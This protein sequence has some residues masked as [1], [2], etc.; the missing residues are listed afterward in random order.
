MGYIAC[1]LDHRGNRDSNIALY[2]NWWIAQQLP[3]SP[4]D[5]AF[6]RCS[7]WHGPWSWL[8]GAPHEI[9]LRLQIR[10]DDGDE[11]S[12]VLATSDVSCAGLG[13]GA[14]TNPTVSFDTIQIANG[15]KAWVVIMFE[16]APGP[17]W[18]STGWRV[19]DGNNCPA[20]ITRRSLDGGISWGAPFVNYPP[21]CADFRLYAVITA[22]TVVTDAATNIEEETVTL[23]GEITA[24][25]AQDA[26]ERGFD[27]GLDT[28]YGNSW[29]ESDSYGIAAFSHAISG[30]SPGTTIHFR[31]KAHN[32]AG[33]G[34]GDDLT[35]VTKPEAC[36]NMVATAISDSQ[37]DVTWTKG[38]GAVNTVVRR[39]VGAYPATIADGEEAYNGPSASFSDQGLDPSTAYYYRAWSY[40]DPHYADAYCQDNATTMA[41]PPAILPPTVTTE[42]ANNINQTLAT[43]NGVLTND[44][45]EACD[46][47]FEYAEV[48]G[49]IYTTAVQGG[50][51]TGAL[52][53]AAL[54]GLTPDTRYH[55]RA[56][57]RNS[58]GTSYGANMYF[59]TESPALVEYSL[60]Q[61]E[62]AELLI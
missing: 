45:G 62:L 35:F 4:G 34:Y 50:K 52:F 26:D 14:Y 48:G 60:L 22:P 20:G 49:T 18:P 17:W 38:D 7:I 12:A 6:N 8:P 16:P 15:Q 37:I 61:P 21:K 28:S 46:C 36:T 3:P 10:S 57:A 25:G 13:E 53:S 9:A 58:T 39:A 44:G 11:P 2:K 32:S 56:I 47:W 40:T 31:A 41:L 43:I 19:D 29:T 1:D 51:T 54:T 27:W 42:S 55:F 59:V 30:L 23:N 24:T 33:W 5:C